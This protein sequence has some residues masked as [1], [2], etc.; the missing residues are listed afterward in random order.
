MTL[1]ERIIELTLFLVLILFQFSC[2]NKAPGEVVHFGWW[3]GITNQGLSVDIAVLGDEVVSVSVLI[4]VTTEKG[5][6]VY[7]FIRSDKT[8]IRIPDTRFSIQVSSGGYIISEEQVILNGKMDDNFNTM[9]TLSGEIPAF[10]AMA[11]PCKQCVFYDQP[12]ITFTASR[13]K[14]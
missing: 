13:G 7:R 6:N 10:R 1:K 9:S 11:N 4:R 2:S 5:S 8:N 14:D 3:R 12:Q